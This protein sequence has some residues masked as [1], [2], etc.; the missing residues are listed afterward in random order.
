MI[1]IKD[2][3]HQ[4]K[5][6]TVSFQNKNTIVSGDSFKTFNKFRYI[7]CLDDTHTRLQN[8]Y[9]GFEPTFSRLGKFQKFR[10]SI[11][12]KYWIHFV[13]KKVKLLTLLIA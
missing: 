9:C 12:V 1:L 10:F 7:Y 2:F 11:A 5:S 8:R 4:N 6:T 3:F 13:L